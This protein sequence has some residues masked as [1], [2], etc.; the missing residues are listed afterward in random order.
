VNAHY[1]QGGKMEIISRIFKL[2]QNKHFKI[3]MY[4]WSG[5]DIHQK[6]QWYTDYFY[7][8]MEH[9]EIRNKAYQKAIRDK[10]KN[11]VVVEVGTG[12]A[13]CLTKMCVEHNA[14]R[15]YTIEEN[16]KAFKSSQ[17]LIRKLNLGDQIKIYPG[18]SLDVELEEKGDVFLHEIIGQIA[19]DEGIVQITAD[20]KKRFL[21]SDAHFIP[22]RCKT[23][24]CPVSSPKISLT[25]K[26][27]NYLLKGIG[28]ESCTENLQNENS[29]SIY[30]FP[31]DGLIG[32]S[33]VL[34]DI[35]FH[36]PF[37]TKNEKTIEW[38][39]SDQVSFNG[40]VFYIQLFV[41]EKTV[42]NSLEQKLNWPVN[43][44]KLLSED[45][46]LRKGDR[47]TTKISRDVSTERPIYTISFR[48]ARNGNVI[49]QKDNFIIN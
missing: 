23:M 43:Y 2:L 13:I 34:E 16:K 29:Y 1:T 11:K 27:A 12:K 45:I 46:I 25:D 28:F 41:D 35:I 47:L 39:I 49:F 19:S 30:N 22:H 5:L 31:L 40:F 7:N 36:A 9:D 6:N 24:I 37:I 20:A 14:K 8:I 3:I 33:Q 26:I 15:V 4:N 38:Q 18:F 21:K 32:D 44:V 48:I 17:E 42:I 10:V